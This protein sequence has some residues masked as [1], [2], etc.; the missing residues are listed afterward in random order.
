MPCKPKR[1]GRKRNESQVRTPVTLHIQR[2]KQVI[3]IKS[4]PDGR[5]RTHETLQEQRHVILVNVNLTKDFIQKLLYPVTR[6]DLVYSGRLVALHHRLLSP[7]VATVIHRLYF[8]FLRNRKDCR[9]DLQRI[10]KIRQ[11]IEFPCFSILLRF[12]FIIVFRYHNLFILIVTEVIVVAWV[13]AVPPCNNLLYESHS[14]VFFP[15]ILLPFRLYRY[16]V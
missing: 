12:R 10:Y 5:K 6:K 2:V 16:F 14:R 8:F 3:F 15:P 13:V 11:E 1:L 7:R 9:T 4:R